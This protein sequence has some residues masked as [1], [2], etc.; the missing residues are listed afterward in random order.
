MLSTFPFL[1]FCWVVCAMLV[2]GFLIVVVKLE[3]GHA[4]LWGMPTVAT[5]LHGNSESC[6][7]MMSCD[8]VTC[9]PMYTHTR[10]YI[11]IYIY[12]CWAGRQ[13]RQQQVPRT[14]P[15][16]GLACT[17]V[18]HLFCFKGKAGA[19]QGQQLSLRAL[20]TWR[21]TPLHVQQQ[22]PAH[23]RAAGAIAGATRPAARLPLLRGLGCCAG[24]CWHLASS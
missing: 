21:R 3:C 6:G 9:W 10:T 1:S 19:G 23:T 22:A 7:N 4:H 24:E 16:E 20:R 15:G 2:G 5:V 11:Y 17:P 18:L 8:H 12:T 14:S 13:G